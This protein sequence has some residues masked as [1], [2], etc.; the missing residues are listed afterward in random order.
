MALFLAGKP[1]KLQAKNLL[2]SGGEADVYMVGSMAVKVFKGPNHADYVLTPDMKKQAKLRLQLV[3]KKLPKFPKLG[4]ERVVVPQALVTDSQKLIAGYSMNPVD[5]AEPLMRLGQRGYREQFA[6]GDT[7][8]KIFRDMYSTVQALHK[9]GVVIGDFNDLNILVQDTKAYFIDADSYQYDKFASVMF[10][11]KFVDPI[12][13]DDA[14][15][16]TMKAGHSELT[17]WYAYAA[18]L[19]Q[20]L[21]CVDPYGGVFKPKDVKQKLTATGRLLNRVTVFHPEVMYPKPALPLG[22][23]PDEL[24]DYFTLVFAKDK[25]AEFDLKLLDNLRFTNCTQCGLEHARAIC[26]GCSTRN[27]AAIAA[28]VTG[29]VIE[30]F[31]LHSGGRIL[32]ANLQYGKLAYLHYE[33]GAFKREDGD[34]V[35]AGKPEKNMRY[36]ISGKT[37]VVAGGENLLFFSPGEPPERHTVDSYKNTP[38]FGTNQSNIFWL[39]QGVLMRKGLFG[40]ERIGEVLQNQTLFWVGNTFG[41]GFYQAGSLKRAF[42]FQTGAKVLNDSVKLPQFMGNLVDADC[43]FSD[44]HA[45]LFLETRYRGKTIKHCAVYDNLGNLLSQ[46]DSDTVQGQPGTDWLSYIHGNTATGN[47]LFASTDEGVVRVGYDAGGIFA[48]SE[49]TDT[50]PH[51]DSHTRLLASD[52]LYLVKPKYISHIQI[53]SPS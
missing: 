7:V 4:L 11:V 37:T 35:F 52:G 43:V 34:T 29:S 13:C 15:G 39:S 10:T 26:P 48:T 28:K 49:F 50:E 2:G 8:A 47:S 20:S 24:L 17:D 18:M 40:P 46:T 42:V 14:G 41:L 31:I 9:A 19:M 36:G 23:L 3:Q 5:N 45:W 33:S 27:A 30:R 6:P 25:R 22:I 44:S 21:V 38:M 16:L 53:K 12:I 51:T 32:R 1:I